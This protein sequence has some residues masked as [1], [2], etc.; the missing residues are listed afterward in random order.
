VKLRRLSIDEHGAFELLA[1]LALIAAPFLLAFNPGALVASVVAGV[2]LA[3]LGLSDGAIATH[4]LADWAIALVLVGLA[5]ALAAS[6][7]RIPAALLAAAAITELTLT[8][9]T[10]WTRRPR[11]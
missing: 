10:R 2:L 7:E 1:G 5:A 4:Q 11:F 9:G 8:A 3:G 6:G